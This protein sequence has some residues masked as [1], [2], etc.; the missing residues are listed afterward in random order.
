MSRFQHY[1]CLG[2]VLGEKRPLGMTE[3]SEYVGVGLMLRLCQ[4]TSERKAT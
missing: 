4:T 2:K 3:R 1:Q